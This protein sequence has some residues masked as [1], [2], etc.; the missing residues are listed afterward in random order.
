MHGLK[1]KD[2]LIL[3]K[4]RCCIALHV[5]LLPGIKD[6]IIKQIVHVSFTNVR[7]VSRSHDS[8]LT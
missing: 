3:L 1:L 5:C 2:E 7:H 6:N 4:I 8:V